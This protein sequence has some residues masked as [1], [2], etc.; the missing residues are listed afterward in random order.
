MWFCLGFP[1]VILCRKSMFIWILFTNLESEIYFKHL[2]EPSTRVSSPP[3]RWNCNLEIEMR[4]STWEP[5]CMVWGHDWRWEDQDTP[6]LIVSLIRWPSWFSNPGRTAY[7][8]EPMKLTSLAFRSRS[9]PTA[10][11]V[12]GH[13]QV[14]WWNASPHTQKSATTKHF[15]QNDMTRI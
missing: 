14:V 7:Y 11:G 9:E 13:I 6:G 4:P 15:K 10:I 8:S 1:V 12:V 3:L 2:W 5:N